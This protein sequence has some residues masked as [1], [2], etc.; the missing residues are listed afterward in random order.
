MSIKRKAVV[1]IADGLGDRLAP[2][3]GSRTPLEAAATPTLDQ[4]AAEGIVGLMDPIKPGV[5]AGSDTAHLSILGMDP[6][7]VYTGR[8]PFEA[9]GIGME[10]RGGDVAFRVNFSTVDD[11]L[12]VTDRRAGRIT[13]GTDQLAR[14][15]DGM[16]LGDGVTAFFKESV[17][18]RGALVLRGQGLG[19]AVTDVDPHATG[20]KVWTATG[21]DPASE[22][23]ARAVN[24][25]VQQSFEV[26]SKHPVNQERVSQGLS[27]ANIALP[28]GIGVAPDVPPFDE[29]WH[30]KSACLVETGLIRGIGIYLGMDI[31]DVP[32]ANGGLDSDVMA[33]ARAIVDAL[34]EHDFVLCNIK[35]PDVAGHDGQAEAKAKMIERIDGAVAYLRANM[36]ADVSLLFTGDHATPCEV[37]DHTGDPVPVVIWGPSLVPDAVT[38]FSER[39]A[40]A[41]GL[42][43]IRGVDVMPI[44]SNLMGVQHKFGA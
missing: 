9:A 14:A 13:S 21:S 18:H 44:M 30:V 42:G 17:A 37:G 36:G 3:L 12:I 19:A 25:F 32:G 16:D 34:A 31:I 39:A 27:P 35:G 22:K 38:T 40:T 11:G 7:A 24:A 5:V 33:T 10:V 6:Y 4:L 28:R 43:R 23:T 29:A 2:S 1:L 41:G 20:E 26:L 15:L 8:G